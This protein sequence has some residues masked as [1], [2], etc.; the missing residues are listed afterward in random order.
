MPC[1]PVE[2]VA[3]RTLRGPLRESL[4]RALRGGLAREGMSA[5]KALYVTPV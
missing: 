3:R 4:A 1:A 5:A 2:D